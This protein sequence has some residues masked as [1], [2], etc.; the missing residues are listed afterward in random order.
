[1]ALPTVSVQPAKVL[2]MVSLTDVFTCDYLFKNRFA[3]LSVCLP[4]LLEFAT[5]ENGE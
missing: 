2:S 4:A 1:M 5:Q 3:V